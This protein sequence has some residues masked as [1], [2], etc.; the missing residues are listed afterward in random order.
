MST[1]IQAYMQ[2]ELNNPLAVKYHEVALK[3]F[4]RVSDIFEINVI[5]CLTPDTLLDTI[6]LDPK[7]PR[8]PQEQASLHSQYR[9]HKRIANGERLWIM[10]HDAYL[11]PEHEDTFRM[12]M[13]KYQQMY[14]CNI[15]IAMECYT[16]H[17][18]VSKMFCERV[19]NDLKTNSTGP[20]GI[21]H[22]VTDIITKDKN[23]Q[24]NNVYWPKRGQD[25]K[26]GLGRTV[27][28]AFQK[29]RK[30]L[31]APVCQL[32]DEQAGTTVIDRPINRRIERYNPKTHPN[33][34]FIDID[35]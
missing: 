24:F 2:V 9:M 11:H 7:K 30:V 22:S 34:K 1:K 25:N 16:A 8:S 33:F 4:E 5:Q 29:P 35:K 32:I 10:E 23:N 26:T 20:M 15:G 28:E 18:I 6:T 21:L 31:D 27:T 12:I 17:P 14:T 3:S 19:E 13:S